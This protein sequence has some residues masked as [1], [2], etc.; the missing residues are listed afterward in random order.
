MENTLENM[1]QMSESD[2][3]DNEVLLPIA[4]MF[5]ANEIVTKQYAADTRPKIKLT[6]DYIN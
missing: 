2:S 6:Y 5:P 1:D 3:Y 4:S